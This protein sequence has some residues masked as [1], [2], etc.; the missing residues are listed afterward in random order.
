[1]VG[2]KREAP[3]SE[4]LNM[5]NNQDMLLGVLVA[6]VVTD[7]LISL[8]SKNKIPSL[9]EKL[10]TMMD[11]TSVLISLGLGIGAGVLTWYWTENK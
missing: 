7:I 4:L 11:D 5:A 3:N 2:I 8:F 9:I 6:Y 1:M 10:Y